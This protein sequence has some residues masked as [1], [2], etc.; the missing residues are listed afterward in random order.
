MCTVV[1]TAFFKLATRLPKVQLRVPRDRETWPS[2]DPS[3]VRAL[4][5]LREMDLQSNLIKLLLLPVALQNFLGSSERKR[6]EGGTVD[7]I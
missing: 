5:S 3:G 2:G 1:S 7:G 6:W 4:A